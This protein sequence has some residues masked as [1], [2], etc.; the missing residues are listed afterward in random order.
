MEPGGFPA[1]SVL[2]V[3]M[4]VLPPCA[5][6]PYHFALAAQAA[7]AIAVV[8]GSPADEVRAGQMGEQWL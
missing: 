8:L 5:T 6:Y 4:A 3:D 7:G 2:F 1:G